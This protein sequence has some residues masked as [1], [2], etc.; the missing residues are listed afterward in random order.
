MSTTWIQVITEGTDATKE[1]ADNTV[2]F[3]TSDKTKTRIEAK[4]LLWPWTVDRH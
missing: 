3:A 2:L 4:L 1:T